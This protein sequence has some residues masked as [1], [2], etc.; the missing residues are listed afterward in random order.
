MEAGMSVYKVEYTARTVSVRKNRTDDGRA[1]KSRAHTDHIVQRTRKVVAGSAQEAEAKVLAES[2][3]VVGVQAVAY[4]GRAVS[5]SQI[6]MNAQV[7][8]LNN[9]AYVALVDG[10]AVGYIE[11][12]GQFTWRAFGLFRAGERERADYGTADSRE[13]AAWLLPGAR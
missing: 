9:R 5:M 4:L 8:E 3:G 7:A 6:H 10:E 2:A 11:A 13:A 1:R 12:D